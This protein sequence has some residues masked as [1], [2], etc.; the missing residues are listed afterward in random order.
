MVIESGGITVDIQQ[1]LGVLKRSENG[2]TKELNLVAWNGKASKYDIRE[3]SPDHTRMT[4]GVVMTDEEAFN[5]FLALLKEFDDSF[6]VCSECGQ[7]MFDGFVINGGD[8][9]YCSEQCLH[10]H[11][12][13]EEYLEMYSD[14]GDTYYTQWY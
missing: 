8:E 7:I 6:R 1:Q 9:Y 10:K 4:R 3:W 11:Y 5:L 12:T 14:D 2:W 13:E